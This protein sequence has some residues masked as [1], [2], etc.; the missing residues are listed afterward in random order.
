MLAGAVFRD[1]GW[2]SA[3][4]FHTCSCLISRWNYRSNREA[5][6]LGARLLHWV[7]LIHLTVR[8]SWAFWDALTLRS[9]NRA[10]VAAWLPLAW[11]ARL[12]EGGKVVRLNELLIERR[13]HGG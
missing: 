10:A 8:T 13:Q 6:L 1:A 5:H 3:P 4:S 9:L 12:C 11:R 7:P 2:K